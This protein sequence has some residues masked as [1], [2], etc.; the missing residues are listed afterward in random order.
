LIKLEKLSIFNN[1]LYKNYAKIKD[2]E[3]DAIKEKITLYRTL[4]PVFWTSA[5][6][7]GGGLYNII[8]K[9]KIWF[10]ITIFTVGIIFEIFLVATATILIFRCKKLIIE[11]K[12]LE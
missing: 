8:S 2:M 12:E 9:I 7:L 1:N 6:I 5:F 3:V 4:I 10:D 11:L